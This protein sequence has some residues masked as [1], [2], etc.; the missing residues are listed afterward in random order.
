[1]KGLGSKGNQGGTPSRT[2]SV[3]P[4]SRQCYP[5]EGRADLEDSDTLGHGGCEYHTGRDS[6][7]TARESLRHPRTPSAPGRVSSNRANNVRPFLTYKSL[8]FRGGVTLDY[9]PVEALA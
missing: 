3:R 7:T 6:T 5:R 4:D 2:A 9:R 1:M 8:R